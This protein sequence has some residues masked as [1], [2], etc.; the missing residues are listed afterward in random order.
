[1]QSSGNEGGVEDN[2]RKLRPNKS[3]DSIGYGKELNS[4]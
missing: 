2:F 1:M 4:H 3:F